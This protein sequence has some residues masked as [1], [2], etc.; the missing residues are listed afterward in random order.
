MTYIKRLI[1]GL[2][3]LQMPLLMSAFC[4]PDQSSPGVAQIDES[5]VSETSSKPTGQT[6]P[7]SDTPA[8]SA[9]KA[10]TSDSDADTAELTDEEI[11]TIFA[12]CMRDFGFSSSDP[13]LNADATVNLPKLRSSIT[14]DSKFDLGSPETRGALQ[15][16]V[17]L[18]QN[19]TFA[20]QPSPEDQ[21]ELQDNILALAQCLRDAG[22][23]IPDPDFSGN[24]RASMRSIAIN[25]QQTEGS[26]DALQSC[27]EPIFGG[28]PRRA[29]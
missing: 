6:N 27:A 25:V 21:L 23:D 8:Q 28:S 20:Q 13:E 7:Q 1:L 16:C 4:G 15:T 10:G 22:L 11:A 9:P 17:P 14:E 3:I 29:R 26:L 2:V 18:L 19:A 5:Q 12:Q 24:I